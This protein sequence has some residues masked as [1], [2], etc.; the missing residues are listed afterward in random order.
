MVWRVVSSRSFLWT[1]CVL[2][3]AKL[4]WKWVA[5]WDIFCDSFSRSGLNKIPFGFII[6]SHFDAYYEEKLI[7]F[8]QYI[9]KSIWNAALAKTRQMIF[10]WL[11]W[12]LGNPTGRDRTGSK[13]LRPSQ[14]FVIPLM[15]LSTAYLSSNCVS[16]PSSVSVPAPSLSFHCHS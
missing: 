11:K 8:C 2:S 5:R 16:L 1:H 14:W 10:N 6:S 7:H 12:Y 4:N 3:W 9:S 15:C 13:D